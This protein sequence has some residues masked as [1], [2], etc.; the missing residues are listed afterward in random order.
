MSFQPPVFVLFVQEDGFQPGNGKYGAVCEYHNKP[1]KQPS[2]L[3][4]EATP[5]PELLCVKTV[6]KKHNCF[7][8]K[9]EYRRRQKNARH[10]YYSKGQEKD[11]QNN[12]DCIGYG[13]QKL[14]YEQVRHCEH[15]A[16]AVL[17]IEEHAPVNQEYLKESHMPAGTL[18]EEGADVG[19][20][21]YS[22]TVKTKQAG[23]YSSGVKKFAMYR[24]G[25]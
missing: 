1:D 24:E 23:I 9:K 11:G 8:E 3:L 14:K 17:R 18:A 16:Q 19:L 4:A 22:I 7:V 25:E 12:A 2:E 5:V 10:G 6:G 13:G 20:R 15:A 21:E